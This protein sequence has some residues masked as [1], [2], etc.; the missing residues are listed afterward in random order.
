MTDINHESDKPWTYVVIDIYSEAGQKTYGDLKKSIHTY[1]DLGKTFNKNN[2][3]SFDSDVS[4]KLINDADIMINI[5]KIKN[6]KQNRFHVLK[7][8]YHT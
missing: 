1:E 7:N 4:K 6:E 8:K 5:K 3:R 2:Y